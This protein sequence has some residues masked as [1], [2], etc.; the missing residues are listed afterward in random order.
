MWQHLMHSGEAGNGPEV[1]GETAW[2]I[3]LVEQLFYRESIEGKVSM[4]RSGV[5]GWH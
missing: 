2:K 4:R 5:C 3:R 1:T